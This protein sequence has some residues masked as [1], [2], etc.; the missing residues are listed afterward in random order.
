MNKWFR[1]ALISVIGIVVSALA[2][3]ILIPSSG[4]SFGNTTPYGYY[5][6]HI[7]NHPQG[8]MQQPTTGYANNWMNN[9]MNQMQNGMN[10]GTNQMNGW[11]NY[12]ANRMQNGMNYG[13]NQMNNWMNYGMG[14][15][16][17]WMPMN[18]GSMNMS[19]GSGMSGGMGMGM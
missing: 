19:S 5:N 9:G 15:M 10:Y 14:Q 6:Q 16:N 1:L 18:G 17:N 12:G 8:A 4:A 2:L 11:M 13:M 3:K 7:Q